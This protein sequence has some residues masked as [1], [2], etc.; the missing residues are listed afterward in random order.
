MTIPLRTLIVEDRQDDALLMVQELR[1]AGFD[2]DWERVENETDYLAH[3]CPDLDVILADYS[4]PQFDAVRALALLQERGL[5]IPFFVVSGSIGEELA[6]S[7]MRKG[8]ADYLLKDR[9]ARLGPAVAHA[10]A[11]QQLRSEKRQAEEALQQRVEELAEADRRKNAF[12]AMLAHELRN[13]LAPLRNALHLLKLPGADSSTHQQA[14]EVMERQVHHLARLV[15]D[16]LDV[17]RLSRGLIQPELAPLDLTQLV[18]VVAADQARAVQEAGLALELQL[19]TQAV[20]VRGDTT[21]L[22]QVFDNL[23]NNA[24]KFTPR[25]G[26]VM[27]R[28]AAEA[29]RRQAVVTIRDTGIGIEPTLLPRVFETFT[30]AD[31]SLDRSRGGLGLGLS[32]VKGLVELHG[33]AVR[34]ASAGLD[35]GAEF[36][37]QLPLLPEP[38]VQ[39]PVSALP[40]H[41][42]RTLRVLVIE[43]NRDT[44]DTLRQVLEMLGHEVAV[45]YSGPAGVEA[46]MEC[47]PDAVLCDIGLP[48]LDG[49]GVAAALRGQPATA[50]ARLVAVTGYGQEDDR[51]RSREAGYDHHLVKPVD[52]DVL[53]ALLCG[54]D[55]VESPPK[56][57][58]SAH[59]Q[60]RSTTAKQNEP[61]W[62]GG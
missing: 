4:L 31:H 3:L 45:A 21:R 34:A 1:Q 26:R 38:A 43:D 40:C 15:D 28:L 19:P 22:T 53:Q 7:A 14:R 36:T 39:S 49:Y 32:L 2:P 13:P 56:S 48:G 37:F 10:L 50:S 18:R 57:E 9:L 62:P 8:A 12:L 55:S 25:G 20:W 17:S 47:R 16:L 42:A 30:Q 41:T 44:A 52:P 6:V 59:A 27:F 5:D 23:L 54:H 58:N 61:C 35:Q 51:R 11:Q 33:G 29:D 46:A 24:V 60:Q